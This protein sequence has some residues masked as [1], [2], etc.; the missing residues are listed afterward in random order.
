MKLRAPHLVGLGLIAAGLVAVVVILLTGIGRTASP[1]A[2]GTTTVHGV[3]GSEKEAFF[4]DPDVVKAFAKHGL[5]V[6]VVTSGSW[7]MAELPDLAEND[8]AF[9]ASPIAAEHITEHVEGSIATHEPFFSPMAIATFEPIMAVLAKNGIA[10]DEGGVWTIDMGRYLDLVE[11]GTRW[12]GLDQEGLAAPYEPDRNVF[13]T[14]T[15]IR[16]SNSAGM[17]LALAAYVLNGNSV[18]SSE[19]D[20]DRY[21]DALSKLFTQQG[22]TDASSAGPFEDYLNLGIGAV[23]MVMV[24]EAQFL[25]AQ[26]HV[27]SRIGEGM[28]LAYPDPTIFSTHTGVTFSDSGEQVMRLLETDPQLAALLARHGYRVNGQNSGAF[29]QYVDEQGLSDTYRSPSGFVNVAQEPTYEVLDS[30]LERIGERYTTSGAPDA[31]STVQR[32]EEGSP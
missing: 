1:F 5:D 13:I 11:Q 4:E 10:D 26:T 17:Y 31:T 22:Y 7:R 29:Q 16:S 25:E 24:Y 6:E 12:S 27:P 2:I 15:D 23:P 18:I 19:A 20:A 28:V 14:S 32:S 30:M 8:F 9:P 3:V 21:L